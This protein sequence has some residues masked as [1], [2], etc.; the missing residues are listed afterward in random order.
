MGCLNSTGKFAHW[1]GNIH[2]SGP[3]NRSCYFCIG[4]HMPSLELLDVLD[5]WPLL[6]MQDFL[7]ECRRR[8]VREVNVTGTN[9]DP[10]LFDALPKLVDMLRREGVTV[11]VRTNAAD[12]KRLPWLKMFN[13]GSVSIHSFDPVIYRSIMGSGEPP[14]VDRIVGLL[15]NVKLNVV[16]CPQNVG[17]GG[18]DLMRTIDKAVGAGVRK[19]NVREPY[20][21]PHNGNP[22][23]AFTSDASRFGMPVYRYL[24]AEV[25]Y[26][27]V[28][29][30]EVES[31]NL[32]ADGTVSVDYPI[33][34][35]Y[36][37]DEGKVLDQSHFKVAKRH[38]PQWGG[39]VTP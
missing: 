5:A 7:S 35:G 29:Y 19:V 16:L 13:K 32:Y 22:F 37:A 26:W 38:L 21:Q 27:D 1:F 23:A 20:G 3:C 30:V 8:H 39:R 14:D 33:T 2:L 11:G 18:V 25:T 15:P 24:G 36:S 17:Y 34:R 31:V 28:H 6:G 4:Q 9:T 10:L 12:V